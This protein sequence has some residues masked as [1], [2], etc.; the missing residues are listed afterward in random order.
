MLGSLMNS[1]KLWKNAIRQWFSIGVPQEVC[2]CATIILKTW[3]W[4][5]IGESV[6]STAHKLGTQQWL[7]PDQ[8][9]WVEFHVAE[10]MHNLHSCYHSHLVYE[11]IGQWQERLEKKAKSAYFSYLI[12][13]CQNIL[14][15]QG[16]VS[17]M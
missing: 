10:F 15:F 5:H 13:V 14:G 3:G 4:C 6:V 7:W 9:W 1:E 16:K 17:I 8:P 11:P 12:M 2:W